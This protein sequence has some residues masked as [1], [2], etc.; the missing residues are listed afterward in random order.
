M[1]DFANVQPD[2][3][4]LLG[5]IRDEALDIKAR[6]AD[7]RRTEITQMIDDIDLDDIIQVEDMAVTMTH[8]G[9]IKR[10]PVAEYKSQH[11]GGQG[12]TGHKAKEEDFVESMFISN[13]H[14]DI[15]ISLT[16]ARFI[17]R[18]RMKSQRRKK[19]HVGARLSTSLNLKKTKRLKRLSH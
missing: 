12:V 14:D 4:K 9:Y 16:L 13:T 15:F 19:Q 6:Y 10:L 8:F 2:E 7:P 1:A 17:A 3:H 5:I 18:V 11:R